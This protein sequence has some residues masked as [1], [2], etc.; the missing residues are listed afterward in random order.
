MGFQLNL[1]RLRLAI[2]ALPINRPDI[3]LPRVA[4]IES[5]MQLA[6][7]GQVVTIGLDGRRI[8]R[9]ADAAGTIMTSELSRLPIYRV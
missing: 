5:T 3:L 2:V 4:D 6:K 7:P 8:V 1:R 9:S